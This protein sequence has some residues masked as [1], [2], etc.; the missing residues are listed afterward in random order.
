V[1]G[2]VQGAEGRRRQEGR[3]QHEDAEEKAGAAR[4]AAKDRGNANAVHPRDTELYDI[5]ATVARGGNE[6][7]GTPGEEAIRRS[8]E[9]FF[10]SA[11]NMSKLKELLGEGLIDVRHEDFLGEPETA[12]E[13]LCSFLGVST[14]PGCLRACSFIVFD[15]PHRSRNRV[16]W[17]GELIESVQE[18]IGDYPFLGG[19][20][21]RG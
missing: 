3:C 9:S 11:E 16:E 21:F 12:L 19:Y 13:K 5:I 2:Q 20:T 18:R 14:D 10:R 7:R 17:P 1:A 8:A 4:T 15:K 6:G